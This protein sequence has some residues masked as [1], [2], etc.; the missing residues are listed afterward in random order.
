MRYFSTNRSSPNAGFREAT[1]LGQPDDKGLYFP[2]RIPRLSK[3]FLHSFRDM[4]NDAIAVEVIK[5]YVGDAIDDE[6]LRHICAETVDFEFPLVEISDR[7]SAVELFHGPTLAFKDVGARFMSRC[8]RY[9]G[10]GRKTVVLVATS[11]D[12]G[13]AVAAGFHGVEG[14]DVVILYPKG[15]V[16]RVQE[17][18]LTTL[19]GN[20]TAIEVD[21]VFDD[22][23]A[24]AKGAL[25]DREIE[26]EI[27]LTSA[28][29]IN[30]ARWLPQQFYYFFALKQ[31]HGDAPVFC[32]PSG[33][34]GNICAGLLAHVSGMPACG[35]IAACNANAVVPEFLSTGNYEP[36]PSV[37][38]LS[39][40]MDVGNPS[41][42]VRVLELFD[43]EFD[44]VT[45]SLSAI[46]ISD[47]QT[48]DTMRDVFEKFGYILD[49]HGAVAY[50]AL[51]DSG[52]RGVVLETAHPIKFDSVAEILGI[53]PDVPGS[54]A[55][56]FDRPS[57]KLEMAVDQEKLKE[58]ILSKI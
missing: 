58:I 10:S 45:K 3:E 29:S 53:R 1:I 2:E 47:E 48:V 56:L 38:T 7:I 8:L 57:E 40:A 32:I 41:N 13:G 34:F 36:K 19:G 39:N 11:G 33:N 21:G 28:N 52:R 37:S 49:P 18:Q 51:E 43:R 9:F 44:Q 26:D 54:V 14:V 24:M 6:S 23:Q 22:C 31:W 35:F 50:R 46:S 25:A 30:I 55:G 17:L 4:P 20:V 16:S 42:F 5:P 12:T 27:F 15:K